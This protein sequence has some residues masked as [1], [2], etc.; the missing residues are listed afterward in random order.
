ML[1]L[2]ALSPNFFLLFKQK[3]MSAFSRA[4]SPF[5]PTCT[6]T[7]WLKF[8]TVKGQLFWTGPGLVIMP[9]S[10]ESE[11][12]KT[13]TSPDRKYGPLKFY[14]VVFFSLTICQP[15]NQQWFHNTWLVFINRSD[16]YC[17]YAVPW[18]LFQNRENQKTK[19]A[20]FKS[21]RT[22]F[23]RPGLASYVLGTRFCCSL[24]SYDTWTKY[25]LLHF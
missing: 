25:G 20:W 6:H 10:C 7:L 22:R 15:K 9:D 13:A 5:P 8:L 2:T 21:S 16:I 1:N 3:T 14:N 17:R 18:D 11:S 19:K 24:Y 4:P 12:A 23:F